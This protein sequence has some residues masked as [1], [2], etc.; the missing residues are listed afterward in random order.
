M[1]YTKKR[2]S[3]LKK[4]SISKKQNLYM[5]SRT[6]KVR[7]HSRKT[8][9]V[10][11]GGSVF[12]KLQNAASKLKNGDNPE[13]SNE[14]N[15]KHMEIRDEHIKKH[16]EK[17]E[18]YGDKDNQGKTKVFFNESWLDVNG[19][20][21]VA[22]I[23][24]K[25]IEELERDN[26]NKL[27]LICKRNYPFKKSTIKNQ[28]GKKCNMKQRC[29]HR[30]DAK[31]VILHKSVQDA[32]NRLILTYYSA[33]TFKRKKSNKVNNTNSEEKKLRKIRI[34]DLSYM[35]RNR[36]TYKEIVDEFKRLHPNKYDAK[37][38]TDKELEY[39]ITFSKNHEVTIHIYRNRI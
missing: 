24:N 26:T 22:E 36:E 17:C 28:N 4:R 20:K 19:G 7:Q 13:P 12:S 29:Y 33:D 39:M 6:K 3:N 15:S 10:M 31:D 32:I 14:D 5:R 21:S 34:K 16:G 23:K 2:I 30:L 11:K 8:K 18:T 38:L 1:T 37:E 25:L 9:R 27:F 35:L